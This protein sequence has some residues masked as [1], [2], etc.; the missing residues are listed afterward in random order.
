MLRKSERNKIRYLLCVFLPR[1]EE[2]MSRSHLTTEESDRVVI[3]F[4]FRNG[5][6]YFF[7]M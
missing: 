6:S 4:S 7:V 3:E 2:L 5:V 1:Q